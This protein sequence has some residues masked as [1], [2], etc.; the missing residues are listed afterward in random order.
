MKINIPCP[1]CGCQTC[2]AETKD[3][4]AIAIEICRCPD[5]SGDFDV[6]ITPQG[7]E[8]LFEKHSGPI[9]DLEDLL[10]VRYK[11]NLDSIEHNCN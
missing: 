7:G 5:G 8:P 6:T 11:I 3:G 4:E 2:D 1:T 10:A 9:Q